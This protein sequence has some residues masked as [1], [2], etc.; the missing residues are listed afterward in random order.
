MALY[1]VARSGDMIGRGL[2]LKSG[3]VACCGALIP[4][5]FRAN[6][7]TSLVLL[8]SFL[9]SPKSWLHFHAFALTSFYN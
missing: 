7:S 6:I 9:A 2:V 5:L 8:P 3:L 1:A 4:P